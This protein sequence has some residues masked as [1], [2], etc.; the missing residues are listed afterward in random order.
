[1]E[2]ALEEARQQLNNIK[3]SWSDKITALENQIHHLNTKM[4]EDQVGTKI[5]FFYVKIL[6]QFQ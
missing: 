1:M 3:A 4:A 5:V 6:C 2:H